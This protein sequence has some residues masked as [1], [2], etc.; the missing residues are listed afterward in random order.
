MKRQYLVFLVHEGHGCF[1]GGKTLLGKTWAVS[2]KQAISQVKWRM[3]KE[4]GWVE[5]PSIVED[6]HGNGYEVVSYIA[7]EVL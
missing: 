4:E 5:P 6:F 1:A 7:E 2:P 3:K